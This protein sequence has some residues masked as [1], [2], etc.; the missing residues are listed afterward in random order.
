MI[1]GREPSK[2]IKEEISKGIL[3]LVKMTE[4]WRVKK[5]RQGQNGRE[6]VGQ[7]ERVRGN[8]RERGDCRR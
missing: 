4:I 5:K 7:S 8:V 1:C 6:R 2:A 3:S